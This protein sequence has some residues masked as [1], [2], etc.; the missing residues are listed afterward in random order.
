LAFL[1]LSVNKSTFRIEV[2]SQLLFVWEGERDA[3][4]QQ[5]AF[6]RAA[7]FPSLQSPPSAVGVC[8]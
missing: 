7:L 2:F 6:P 4:A 8:L 5:V 1:V 3:D